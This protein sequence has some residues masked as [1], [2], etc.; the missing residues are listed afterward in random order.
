MIAIV[1]IT[2]L[3]LL[4]AAVLI[5]C[6]RALQ[7]QRMGSTFADSLW[8]GW[9]FITDPGTHA[10][11]TGWSNRLAGATVTVGGIMLSAVVIAF[12]VD[13]VRQR[14]D[15]LKQGRTMVVESNHYLVVGWSDKSFALIQELCLA[16]HSEGGGV[17]V[18]LSETDKLQLEN[19]IRSH[20]SLG[21]L[22][23]TD[24]IC[25]QGSGLLLSDLKKVSGTHCQSCLSLL[26]SILIKCLSSVVQFFYSGVC[27]RNHLVVPRRGC[28]Q[29]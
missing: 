16:M 11:E 9:G 24:I 4:L 22:L 27:A 5:E 21:D 10:D 20:F 2:A 29:G 1:L 26:A 8:S 17:V 3:L 28:Q 25:R 7:G 18:V 6:G 15:S 13:G 12:V 19:E 14:L 23:G